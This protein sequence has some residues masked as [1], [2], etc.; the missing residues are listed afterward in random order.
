[1]ASQ[2]QPVTTTDV[3]NYMGEAFAIG[4]TFGK[5]PVLS[6][7]QARNGA[8]IA[9]STTFPMG[10]AF[11]GDAPAQ[12]GVTEDD[13]IGGGT[14]TS[15]TPAQA[16]NTMQIFQ[17]FWLQSFAAAAFQNQNSGVNTLQQPQT[18]ST[19]KAQQRDLHVAQTMADYEYSALRGTSQAWTNAGTT[20]A[21]GG[22]VTAIEAGSETAAVGATLSK[23]LIKTEIARMSAAGAEFQDLFLVGGAHQVQVLDDLYGN[24]KESTTEGGTDISIVRMPVAGRATILF[25]PILADDDL[26]FIDMAHVKPV[27]AVPDPAETGIAMTAGVN[28]VPLALTTGGRREMLYML[29]SI[30]WDATVFHGMISGLA[31][32]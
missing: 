21:M 26:I 30:D 27:F 25:D 6:I 5:S 16:T 20:G 14:N 17:D 15:Y 7:A 28:I 32:S 12:D 24:A 18:V 11:T 29:A 3:L 4:E 23:S 22:L 10:N 13:S 19:K 2:T 1:M 31:T 9:G 8:D